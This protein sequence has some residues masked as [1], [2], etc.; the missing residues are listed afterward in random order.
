[1]RALLLFLCFLTAA[2]AFA[3]ALPVSDLAVLV[4]AEGTE[5][6]SDVSAAARAADFTPVPHGFAAGYTRKT[7]WLRFRIDV[8]QAGPLL[9]EIQPPYLDDVRLYQADAG[10]PGGWRET[11]GGDLLPFSMREIATRNPV[12]RVEA[13]QAGTQTLYL[14]IQTSST[15]MA[16]LQAWTAADHDNA[17]ASEYLLLGLY[18]GLMVAMLLFNLWHG[19]W[20]HD[21]AHRAFLAYLLGVFAF[22]LGFNGLIAQYLAPDQPLFGQHWLSALLFITTGLGAHFH[23]VILGID[24]RTPLLRA[25]FLG[26]LWLSLGCLIAYIA[27]YFT[28][29][30]RIITLAAMLVPVLG[31]LRTLQL[32]RGG[33]A[34]SSLLA[35]AYGISLFSYLVSLLSLQGFLHSGFIQVYSFQIGSLLALLTFNF[36]LF[37]RLRRMQL[38][39]DAALLSAHEARSERDAESMARQR[40]SALLAMLTHELKTPLSVI[41][42]CLGTPEA[43]PRMQMHAQMSVGE[44]ARI[45]ERCDLASRLDEAAVSV[46]IEDCDL[47]AQLTACIA[48]QAEGH[49]I[50]VSGEASTA[51][52]DADPALLRILLGNLLENALKYSP[53]D[54]PV[55]VAVNGQVRQ[56]RAGYCV[57]ISNAAGSA[58]RPDP[59]TLFDKY[60]RAPAAR[61]QS[62]SGLGLYI[63][64]TVAAMM[65][66]HIAFL[67]DYKEIVFELWLPRSDS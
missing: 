60:Y 19:H 36:S 5:T 51:R 65:D 23:H 12:F 50:R 20:R 58:G 67:P 54:T 2:P 64:R 28:E 3:T 33:D 26:M 31:L 56:A 21:A 24:R 10:V 44:I 4:D 6:I 35:L 34:G 40:Q 8:P 15:S 14:R 49:R 37:S 66:A 57:R 45:V 16:I 53:A 17:I 9:L 55:Q 25:Y 52:V 62:G 41:R 43:S 18:Y 39:R 42:L 29:A 38:E 27:G 30:A 61:S 48:Q 1:M 32:W 22:M 46:H 7:H 13:P 59:D 63:V 11:R 47:E